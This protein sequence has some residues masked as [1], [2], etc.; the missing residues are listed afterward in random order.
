MG[1]YWKLFFIVNKF[2]L[3]NKFRSTKEKLITVIR[4]LID[5]KSSENNF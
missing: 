5:I 2:Y 3:L 1:K 4:K